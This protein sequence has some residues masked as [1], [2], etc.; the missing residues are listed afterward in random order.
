M[1]LMIEMVQL[2]HT[3]TP[4]DYRQSSPQLQ[5]DVPLAA[6]TTGSGSAL[7]LFLHPMTTRTFTS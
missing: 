4:I 7:Q 6:A 2:K 1:K 5:Q 3:Q